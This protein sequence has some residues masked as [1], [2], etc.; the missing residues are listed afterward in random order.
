[1]IL[2]NWSLGLSGCGGCSVDLVAAIFISGHRGGLDGGLKPEEDFF[3]VEYFLKCL[4]GLVGNNVGDGI[5]AAGGWNVSV[6]DEAGIG[7]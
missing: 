3:Y 2:A 6:G 5:G 1:M 4:A 7:E